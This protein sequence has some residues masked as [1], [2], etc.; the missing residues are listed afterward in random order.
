MCPSLGEARLSVDEQR[1][2]LDGG[3]LTPGREERDA[4]EKGWWARTVP[5]GRGELLVVE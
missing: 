5:Q 3:G 1:A 4:A 2:T